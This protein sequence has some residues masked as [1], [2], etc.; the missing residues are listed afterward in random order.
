ML[1]LRLDYMRDFAM[2]SAFSLVETTLIAS[3]SVSPC[4]RSEEFLVLWLPFRL[5][6]D[7]LFRRGGQLCWRVGLAFLV[8]RSAETFYSA[9][10]TVKLVRLA[11]TFLANE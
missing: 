7:K 3:G 10:S 11:F 1:P 6:G 4:C 9:I 8:M 2:A 5:I